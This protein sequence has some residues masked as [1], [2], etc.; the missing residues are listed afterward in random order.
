[1]PSTPPSPSQST[2]SQWRRYNQLPGNSKSY[3]ITVGPLRRLLKKRVK[4]EWGT[5]QHNAIKEVTNA[6][7]KAL[8]LRPYD[9][10]GRNIIIV[11]GS[12]IGLGVGFSQVLNGKEYTIAFISR[13]LK[14]AEKHYDRKVLAWVRAVEKLM[15]FEEKN[16]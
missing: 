6:T 4:C 14:D 8:T 11:F 1:M 7:L 10:N 3:V 2:W 5:D 16:V 15:F 13:G 12:A 9:P